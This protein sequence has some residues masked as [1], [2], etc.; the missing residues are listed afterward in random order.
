MNAIDLRFH[1]A[2]ETSGFFSLVRIAA[3]GLLIVIVFAIPTTGWAEGRFKNERLVL[4][5]GALFAD[6][7]SHVAL[8]G[9]ALIGTTLDLE[10]DLGLDDSDTVITAEVILRLT[11]H[12][13]FEF[14]YTSLNRNA[15]SVLTAN[16]NFGDQTFTTTTN[17]ST[18]LDIDLYRFAYGISIV[19]TGTTEFGLSIGLHVLDIDA[20]IVDT[21]GA[22]TER[23]NVSMPLPNFGVYAGRE[24]TKSLAV[25]GKYQ[26]FRLDTGNFDG[27]MTNASIA[28]EYIPFRRALMGH[29]LIGG[30][31]S[32]F[33][34]DIE[35]NSSGFD[36]LVEFRVDGPMVY[37]G[38]RF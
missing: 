36:G 10:D 16:I 34:L 26:I 20:S 15:S 4:R 3:M 31:Y 12:H 11:D 23:E 19:N 38:V 9:L 17:V 6:Y 24:I 30:G 35:S 14:G 1:R 27:D 2:M 29:L 33:D 18:T 7:D 21:L 25:V 37:A 5:V 8:D 22:V 28:L 32:F 13:R